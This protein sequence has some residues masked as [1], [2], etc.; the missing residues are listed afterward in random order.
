M[1]E[2]LPRFRGSVFGKVVAVMVTMAACLMLLLTLF[3]WFVVMSGMHERINPGTAHEGLLVLFVLVVLGIL[4]S[5]HLMLRHLL[6]PLGELNDAVTRLG[7]GELDVQ[8]RRT[9][10]DEFGRLTDA[11]NEMVSRVREMIS[12]RDQLLIGV[13]HELRSPLTRLKVALELLP[14]DEQ[15]ARLSTDV[16]EMERMVAELLELERLR[17]GGGIRA[18]RQD[19]VPIV[20]EV[21]ASFEDRPPGVRL[22]TPSGEIPVDID[23]AKIRTVLRN[24][25][26]NATKYSLHD[27]RAIEVSVNLGA[28]AAVVRITDDGV[29]IPE[30]DVARIFEPFFRVDPSRSKSTGGYGLGLSICKRVMEAH[31]GSIAV[32][33]PAGRGTSFVLTFPGTT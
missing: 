12:A 14:D 3:F 15:R 7:A 22:I 30:S 6:R 23:A 26:E 16:A 4:V 28:R 33:R 29:G 20:R 17:A 24:L 25:L 10:V 19:L 27:S 11:F 2:R 13:S 21:A 18:E 32:E 8:V 5:A 31:G 1:S 9:T